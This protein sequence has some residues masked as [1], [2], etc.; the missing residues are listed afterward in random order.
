LRLFNLVNDENIDNSKA[1]VVVP[2]QK[3]IPVIVDE[4]M[5]HLVARGF[6]EMKM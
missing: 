6:D 1:L 3:V 2:K 4:D 5:P